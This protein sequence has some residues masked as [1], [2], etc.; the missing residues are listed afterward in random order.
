MI[1]LF[2]N[3]IKEGRIFEALILGQNIVNRKC[4]IVSTGKYID[5]LLALSE[6]AS[7]LSQKLA[8]LNRA[9][10]ILDYFSENA[11]LT[12]SALDFIKGHKER[13]ESRRSMISEQIQEKERVLM[14][15]DIQ[16]N[17]EAI[18]LI[19]KLSDKLLTVSDEATMNKILEQIRQL[20]GKI[21][22]DL[23]TAEQLN[24]YELLT[25][26]CADAVT[27][28]SKEFD[29]IKNADYNLRAVEA[30]ERAFRMFKNADE[31]I[32][33]S[34]TITELFSFD[35]SRLSAETLLYYNHVYSYIFSKL[36]D[37]EKFA[38]TKA[39]IIYQ[40]RRIE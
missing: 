12:E 19:S 37:K 38:F 27:T 11:D 4:E 28:K 23:L 39:A 25:K 5:F 22:S 2:N 18:G 29:S 34:K 21:K 14:E 9:D 30:Y 10:S 8:Y 1:S 16:F 13:I 26:K 24:E 32:D 15:K 20:D 35:A 17:T 36:D 31:S 7:A 6:N 40:K 33:I 3:C